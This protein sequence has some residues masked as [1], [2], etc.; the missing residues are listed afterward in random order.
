MAAIAGGQ[1]RWNRYWAAERTPIKFMPLPA[2]WLNG[3]RFNDQPPPIVL[4]PKRPQDLSDA[5]FRALAE[6]TQ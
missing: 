5:E 4:K 2:S 6:A 1:S 3:D